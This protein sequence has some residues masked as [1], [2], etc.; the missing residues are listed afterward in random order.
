MLSLSLAR[1]NSWATGPAQLISYSFLVAEGMLS[2][3]GERWSKLWFE[4]KN[5]PIIGV[6][7]SIL[8]DGFNA[9]RAFL[10][11]NGIWV[12]PPSVQG[13][14][15]QTPTKTS[16]KRVLIL[17]SVIVL[18]LANLHAVDVLLWKFIN[19]PQV[20]GPGV[21]HP[22]SCSQQGITRGNLAVADWKI[23]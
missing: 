9:F 7:T 11:R 18:E 2:K 19:W 5:D 13:G 10:R 21:S 14:S 12:V 8:L 1:L 20:F 3:R 15:F 23:P 4:S 16:K 6:K 22:N 17:S